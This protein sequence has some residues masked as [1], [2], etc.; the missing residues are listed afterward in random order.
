M[1]HA[2]STSGL[3]VAFY[4]REGPAQVKG[5]RVYFTK[6][7]P[8]SKF[9]VKIIVVAW[10]Y[11]RTYAPKVQTAEPV[12]QSFYLINCGKSNY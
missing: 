9:P 6:M 4:V 5:N 7:P 1:L 2:A 11:G 10:Q 8:R 3:P 12:E